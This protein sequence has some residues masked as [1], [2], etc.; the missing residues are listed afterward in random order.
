MMKFEI[1]SES[2][3]NAIIYVANETKMAAAEIAAI[4]SVESSMRHDIITGSYQG[5]FQQ[6]PE[7]IKEFVRSGGYIGDLKK[8][9]YNAEVT[10]FTMNKNIKYYK[11]KFNDRMPSYI[12]VYMMHQQGIRG[13]YIICRAMYNT[14]YSRIVS[15]MADQ[16]KIPQ[17]LAYKRISGNLPKFFSNK[18]NTLSVEDFYNHYR[19]KLNERRDFYQELQW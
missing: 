8:P 18:I 5:L 3:K 2:E 17:E 13:G 16:L 7:N 11:D 6:G 15:I 14:P 10:A 9:Q 4:A 19:T 12:D 1:P